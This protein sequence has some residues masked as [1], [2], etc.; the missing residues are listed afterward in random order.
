[1]VYNFIIMR[2]YF[3]NWIIFDFDFPFFKVYESRNIKI[4]IFKNKNINK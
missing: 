2:V 1:M 4:Q 3:S